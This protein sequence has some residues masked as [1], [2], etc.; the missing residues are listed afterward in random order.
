MIWTQRP[1]YKTRP[2]RV[3]A[4]YMDFSIFI[5][6]HSDQTNTFIWSMERT[7]MASGLRG[8]SINQT[9]TLRAYH[10]TPFTDCRK[11]AA[12]TMIATLDNW[13]DSS[14]SRPSFQRWPV[15]RR[16][17]RTGGD[18]TSQLCCVLSSDPFGGRQDLALHRPYDALVGTHDA[19]QARRGAVS[20]NHA[21]APY[22]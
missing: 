12:E 15:N 9:K 22:V 3:R 17:R 7:W 1:E 20:C 5:S 2:R 14:D 19:D 18:G 16:L 6:Y 11:S 4:Y 10:G 13:L 21:E 8:L